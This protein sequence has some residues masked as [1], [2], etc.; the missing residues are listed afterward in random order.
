MEYLKTKNKESSIEE[1]IGDAL[2]IFS[3][4]ETVEI[5][6]E[7]LNIENRYSFF[8]K[9]ILNIISEEFR[10]IQKEE[11]ETSKINGFNVEETSLT[12]EPIIKILYK[13]PSVF[14]KFLDEYIELTIKNIEHIKK[15]SKI[16]E[17]IYSN[18]ILP[19]YEFFS[20]LSKMYIDNKKMFRGP[21][22]PNEKTIKNK[23]KRASY[24]SEVYNNIALGK[25]YIEKKSRYEVLLKESPAVLY[26]EL[27]SLEKKLEEIK[28]RAK[29]EQLNERGIEF[30]VYYDNMLNNLEIPAKDW[31]IKDKRDICIKKISEIFKNQ[32]YNEN[33]SSFI[34]LIEHL[35]LMG[36]GFGKIL[37][38]NN[39]LNFY[40]ALTLKAINERKNPK[41]YL[42]LRHM[43]KEYAAFFEN[44]IN[45]LEKKIKKEGGKENEKF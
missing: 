8:P 44:V 22:D 27:T 29:K 25:V 38:A 41:D 17:D 34:E 14:V 6:S 19:C 13:K 42:P 32:Q 7:S 24:L 4:P 21:L 3:D 12:E 31:E 40:S 9:S 39:T 20:N 43:N 16:N 33:N 10:E 1:V 37:P 28:R 5:I 23:I 30:L 36:F 26:N 18:S 15:L 11:D 45:F 2:E 35:E